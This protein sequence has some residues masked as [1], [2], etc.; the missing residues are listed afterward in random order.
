MS[1]NT[2][3]KKEIGLNFDLA[4]DSRLKNVKLF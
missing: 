2:S 4:T 3:K 1:K